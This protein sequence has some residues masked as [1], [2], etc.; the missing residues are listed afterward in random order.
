M[1]Q[2]QSADLGRLL[3]GGAC[4]VSELAVRVLPPAVD[5]GFG[6]GAGVVLAGSDGYGGTGQ[7]LDLH[8]GGLAVAGRLACLAV[9]VVPPAPDA[10]V[11]GSAGVRGTGG[12][13]SHFAFRQ[14]GNLHGRL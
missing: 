3:A 6:N 9:G 5:V 11:D 1:L 7:S 8:G 2:G 13:G 14:P 10:A 12:Q 4:P